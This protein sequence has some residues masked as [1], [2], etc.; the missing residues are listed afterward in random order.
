MLN[1]LRQKERLMKKV[2]TCAVLTSIACVLLLV[3]S[4][5]RTVQ[6]V[7]WS[8]D[9]KL[10]ASDVGSYQ[11]F[12]Y[13]VAIDGNLAIVGAMEHSSNTGA[14]YI[15]Q[16]TGSGWTQIK[17]L[18]ASDGNVDDYFG[19]SVGI[20]GNTAIVGARNTQNIGGTYTGSAYIFQDTGLGWTESTELYADD[21]TEGDWFGSGV[22]IDGNIAIIG[23]QGDSP[24]G[25]GS[26]SAYIFTRVLS[27][28]SQTTRFFPGDGDVDDEFGA[29]VDISGSTAVIGAAQTD[30]NGPRSGSEYVFEDSGTGWAEVGRLRASDAAAQDYF[31]QSVAIDGRRLIVGAPRTDDNATDAG[32]AYVFGKTGLGGWEQIGHL[33]AS[34]PEDQ[35]RLGQSVAVHGSNYVVGAYRED[36][37]GSSA[38]AAYTYQESRFSWP[39]HKILAWDGTAGDEFGNAVGIYNGDIIVA[40]FSD[41]DNGDYAGSAYTFEGTFIPGDANLDDMIDGE[42]LAIWQQYYDP[43]GV[44]PG[45]GWLTADWDEDGDVDG[46][47]LATWQQNY[48]PIGPIGGTRFGTETVPEPATMLMLGT[49]LAGLAGFIRRRKK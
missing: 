3:S 32:S 43:L 19:C 17:K 45:N 5:L 26:G 21:G 16:N 13:S 46:A 31:G 9:T 41:S 33:F 7:S 27:S 15:F 40:A 34:D 49:G 1:N 2:L 4:Q 37:N 6:A 38:G 14:A 8:E 42:D 10:V 30:Y 39:Q 25:S 22:A 36:A 23:A 28:W 47:D 44:N 24:N 11:S 48:D 20:S 18:T 12:G 35:D 29:V